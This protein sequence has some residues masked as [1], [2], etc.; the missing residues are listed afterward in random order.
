MSK[1]LVH[2]EKLSGTASSGTFAVNT[3]FSFNGLLRNI[4]IKPTTATNQYDITI[5]NA[6]SL[7]IY[8]RISKVGNLS[9]EVKLPVRGIYTVTIANATI[10]EAFTVHLVIE[11]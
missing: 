11:E 3:V 6:D 7:D 10:D 2:T 9:D 8:S 5:T 4:L 1:I